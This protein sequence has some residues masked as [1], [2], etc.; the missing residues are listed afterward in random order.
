MLFTIGH[1]SLGIGELTTLLIETEITGIVDVRSF[2][3]SRRFPHFAREAMAQSV[4]ATGL[5]YQWRPALGGRRKP[6]PGSPNVAWRNP[7]FQGYADYMGSAP[8]LDALDHLAEDAGRRD[9]AVMCSESVW[10]RCHRRLISDAAVLLRGVEVLHLFHDGRLQTHP[11]TPE[12]R[13]EA[14]GVLVYDLGMT[15]PLP[16]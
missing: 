16:I 7:S 10:W 6:Q 5:G 1:G 8:F 14:S 3:G 13:V 4:P 2:P 11:P 9:L 15:P 12:A